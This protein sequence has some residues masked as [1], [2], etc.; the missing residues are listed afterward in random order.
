MT[1]FIG[2]E[3]FC[4]VLVEICVLRNDNGPRQKRGF[5]GRDLGTAPEVRACRSSC[6]AFGW[7]Q[8]RWLG[9]ETA[10]HFLFFHLLTHI[11]RR[12]PGSSRFT[13]YPLI[14]ITRNWP[15]MCGDMVSFIKVDRLVVAKYEEIL[16]KHDEAGMDEAN[17][18]DRQ[19][20]KDANS[21]MDHLVVRHSIL[22]MG[23]WTAQ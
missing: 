17:G 12:Y 1:S 9:R 4:N 14:C 18:L 6:V 3:S 21:K 19:L 22:S 5:G 8:H 11:R 20:A 23:Q 15:S 7:W 13:H 2:S 16:K 10:S